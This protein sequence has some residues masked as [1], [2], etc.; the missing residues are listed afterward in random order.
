MQTSFLGN[1]MDTCAFFCEFIAIIASVWYAWMDD[2][3]DRLHC[4]GERQHPVI[5]AWR[6]KIRKEQKKRNMIC[7]NGWR[8]RSSSLFWGTTAPCNRS[9]NSQD[10]ERTEEEEHRHCIG[11]FFIMSAV[12]LLKLCCYW[13]A[14]S[15]RQVR[16]SSGSWSRCVIQPWS[17]SHIWPSATWQLGFLDTSQRWAPHNAQHLTWGGGLVSQFLPFR[18]FLIFLSLSKHM[19]AVE[20]HVYIWQVSPQLSCS[21]TCQI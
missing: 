15:V 2:V 21:D 4:S 1:T 19:L 12:F 14:T 3:E 8:R 20:Y 6:V 7:L 10:Q 5:L 17:T 9:M 18:Y 16:L 11:P 13:L